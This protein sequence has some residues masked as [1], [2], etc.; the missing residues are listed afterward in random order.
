[1]IDKKE[2]RK[3]V[4]AKRDELKAD[5]ALSLSKAI[6]EKIIGMREFSD[7]DIVLIY[8]SIRNEINTD[9]LLTAAKDKAVYIP[10]VL[11][12]D[13]M[14]F[15]E[16]DGEYLDGAFGIKEPK[17]TERGLI[18]VIDESGTNDKKMNLLMIMPGAVYDNEKHRIG[19]G[20]GFYDRYIEKL[21]KKKDINLCLVAPAYSFQ[22]MDGIIPYT[23]LDISPD[24]I[25]TE[26]YIYK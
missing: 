19:Y 22:L 20:G 10:K 3:E 1:M 11:S 26:E 23:E 14:E 5:V 13:E 24:I 8:K 12:S 21:R 4:L 16:D 2:I 18:S 9:M 17:N 25:V 7:S 6:C 15:Y